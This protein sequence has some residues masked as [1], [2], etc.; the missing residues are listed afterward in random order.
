MSEIG[1]GQRLQIIA[2][3]GGDHLT[4]AFL[5]ALVGMISGDGALGPAEALQ[6]GVDARRDVCLME[7]QQLLIEMDG[8][9]FPG[10]F[11]SA[12]GFPCKKLSGRAKRR[13]LI[14][15]GEG[16]LGG[17]VHLLFHGIEGEDL[18]DQKIVEGRAQGVGCRAFCQQ[19]IIVTDRDFPECLASGERQVEA[20][21][22]FAQYAFEVPR[23]DVIARLL[24]RLAALHELP[25]VLMEILPQPQRL[26]GLEYRPHR[27]RC[28]GQFCIHALDAAD[29]I[30]A[31]GDA[32]L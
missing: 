9:E 28:L 12:L 8:L 11:I 25:A 19:D 27:L 1:A 21:V 26:D 29:G 18:M 30:L 16:I 31:L 5:Q 14:I 17:R 6:F 7:L 32:P 24:G 4:Q 22:D 3:G 10:F 13:G 23:L 15:E 2:C 20:P